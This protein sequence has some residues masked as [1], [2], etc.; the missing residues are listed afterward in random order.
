MS[1]RPSTHS[2]GTSR[3]VG[4]GSCRMQRKALVT[5]LATNSKAVLAIMTGLAVTGAM[6]T[7]TAYRWRATPAVPLRPLVVD[8]MVA[9]DWALITIALIF[10]RRTAQRHRRRSLNHQHVWSS[11]AS[12]ANT[13][14]RA[15]HMS[16]RRKCRRRGA[17]VHVVPS[18]LTTA[19]QRA[20]ATWTTNWDAHDPASAA[21]MLTR[22]SPAQS[23]PSRRTSTGGTGWVRDSPGW[24]SG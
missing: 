5:T 1:Q 24:M 22:G 18:A 21:T 9:T 15:A 7:P 2:C 17:T 19:S 16:I 3:L 14:P 23:C 6:A 4:E 12:R 8:G 11:N 20:T 10:V 13:S